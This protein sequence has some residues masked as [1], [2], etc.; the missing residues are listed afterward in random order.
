MVH[1]E[2]LECED[3]IRSFNNIWTFTLV[4]FCKEDE[5]KN[6]Y[7]CEEIFTRS[8]YSKLLFK[9]GYVICHKYEFL[10]S[11][12]VIVTRVLKLIVSLKDL[13]LVLRAR[14]NW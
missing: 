11:R 14:H 4:P 2:E 13:S 9:R 12:F 7:S 5:K 1:E 10:C 3:D 8:N 6:F